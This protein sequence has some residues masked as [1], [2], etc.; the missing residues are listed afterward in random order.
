MN[1]RLLSIILLSF[2]SLPLFPAAF[3][4]NA[5]GQD[6]GMIEMLTGSGYE[7]EENG[8]ERVIYHDGEVM[9]RRI[10]N[11]DGYTIEYGDRTER[12]K[13]GENG[14]RSEWTV[15]QGDRTETHTYFYTDDRLSSVSVSVDGEL[16]R[17]LVYLETPSGTVAAITGTNDSY[18]SPSFYLYENDGDAV[19]FTYYEN[20]LVI[21]EDLSDPSLS[22]TI[23]DDGSWKESKILP[24]GT[25]MEKIFDTS[26]RLVQESAG[27]AVTIYEYGEDG[28]LQ[29]SVVQ[30]GGNETRTHY[31]DGS[32]SS[33]EMLA[34]GILTK[35]RKFLESGDIEEIRYKEG[36]AE[37][38][39]LFEGD[40]VRVKEIH[41][42]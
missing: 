10:E 15:E 36:R 30:D 26:G 8:S 16:Q 13:L 5:L 42:L 40:G 12:V 14:E 11:E 3:L 41:R 31:T 4:S 32:V 34:D 23:E 7:G 1:R 33:I 6:L 29:L 2:L 39:I 20:G 24:D 25:V 27:E 35:E 21:R 22:Y 9:Q 18:I 38:S 17:R 28:E 37:Y 19:K